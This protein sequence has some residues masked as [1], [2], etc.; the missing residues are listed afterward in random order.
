MRR[1]QHLIPFVVLACAVLAAAAPSGLAQRSHRRG[2]RHH[3]RHHRR[4]H[5]PQAHGAL[6]PHVANCPVFPG[7]NPWNQ[8][9]DRLPVATHSARFIS[10]IGSNAPVMPD[11]GSP[12]YRG[13]VPLGIPYTVV[14][15][16]THWA[17][18]SFRWADQSNRGAYPLPRNV[19]I[20]GGR[21]STGDRHVI[22][23]DRQNC[24]DYELYNAWPGPGAGH[25]TADAGAIFDLRSNQL[26]PAGWTSADAA[27]LPLLAALARYKEVARGAIEH[28]LRFT[29]P[30]TATK[31]VYPARH[32][33]HSC[34]GAWLPPM[35][36]RVRLKSSVRIA[37]FPYQARVIAIALKRYGMILAD[38]GGPWEVSGAPDAHWNDAA[39]L[40]LERLRGR[41]FQV[42]NMASLPHPG[43]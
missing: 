12:V 10:R 2:I 36:L 25:W 33:S 16:H 29:A 8:R 24:R 4:Q 13:E 34:G 39:L 1:T 26:R 15:N 32:W 41:D 43:A 19:H 9:V 37:K 42:V 28:A 3:R 22:I 38:N 18:T 11:F 17:G 6:Y 40:V 14:T 20:Q 21:N 27:G 31:Y 7:N 35:G 5:G 23:V 30:C